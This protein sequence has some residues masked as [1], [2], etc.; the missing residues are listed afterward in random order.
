MNKH[1]IDN[2]NAL[3]HA[4]RWDYKEIASMLFNANAEI[5]AKN[6]NYNTALKLVAI[7]EYKDVIKRLLIYRA[8]V[9]ESIKRSG[10]LL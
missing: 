3:H 1:D 5:E 9:N 10:N 2:N 4:T 6:N 8:D 7:N